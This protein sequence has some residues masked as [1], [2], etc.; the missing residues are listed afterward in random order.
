MAENDFFDHL[1]ILRRKLVVAVLV[2]FLASTAAFVCMRWIVPVVEAPLKARGL[3][4]YAFRPQERLL[5]HLG[6]ALTC[7][8]IVGIP[9]LAA[10][11]AMFVAPGLT[12]RER[13]F[14]GPLLL[15]LFLFSASG[16]VFAALFVVPTAIDFFANY[17]NAAGDRISRELWSVESY[18]AFV[19]AIVGGTALVFTLP[20]ILLAAVRAGLLP[21]A[22]LS[23]YRRH[24]VI[25]I[26]AIAAIVTPPDIVSQLAVGIPLVLLYEATALAARFIGGKHG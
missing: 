7:G 1:E 5:A 4:L 18:F 24:A 17:A 22:V 12:A 3:E 10:Q 21:P 19:G 6:L 15:A 2:F 20:P 11:I 23:R 25:G 8:L 26:F 16:A 9:A 13:R 14:A